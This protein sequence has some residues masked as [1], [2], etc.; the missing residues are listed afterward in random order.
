MKFKVG[1]VVEWCGIYGRVEDD[2]P[3]FDD[4]YPIF[5]A[6]YNE[7]DFDPVFTIDGK[8]SRFHKE[9][10]LKL[11]TRRYYKVKK[12]KVLYAEKLSPD[13][14]LISDS[15]YSSE[16]DFELNTYPQKL[17]FINLIEDTMVEV[18]E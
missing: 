10:S 2:E 1:D 6:F 17:K 8:F 16:D 7:V 4:N 18:E 5:V 15:L 14:L 11:I 3:E 13:V 9:P 12:Y